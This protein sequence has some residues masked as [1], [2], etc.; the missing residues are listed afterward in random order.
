MNKKVDTYLD[1]LNNFQQE[2][3]ELR[4]IILDCTLDEAFK[5]KHPCYTYNDKNILLIHKFKEY[6]AISFFKGALLK[7]EKNI[8]FQ[9][10]ENVQSSR[11][12]RFSEIKEIKKLESVIK[13]YIFEAIEVEKAG[14]NVKTKKVAD[15]NVPEELSE[16]FDKNPEFQEAFKALTPGRQKGYLLHFGQAK[17]SKTRTTRIEKFEKR[18]FDGKGMNDC[19][20]GLSK[21]MPNCDGSHNQL[22][23]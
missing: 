10:T 1:N 12:L 21:R 13:S 22:K 8:L 15:F 3:K 20:C 16:K 9:Q 2:L 14:L 4:K 7:D 18:I 11:M 17:Q 5:W 23:N 6:C 19:V